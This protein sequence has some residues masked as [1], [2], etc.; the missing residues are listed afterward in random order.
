MLPAEVRHRDIHMRTTLKMLRRLLDR[1]FFFLSV[2]ALAAGLTVPHR[3]RAQ[4]RIFVGYD[5]YAGFQGP[6]WAAK[7]LGLFDKYGLNAALVLIPGS[8]RAMAALLSD[9]TQFAQG[10]ASAPVPVRMRGGDVVMVAAALNKFAVSFVAQKEIQ[11][12][13]DLIGKKVGILNFGGSNDLAVTL[14]FRE[15]NIPRSAVTILATGGAAERLAALSAKVIDATVLA[16]PE[17]VAATRMGMSFLGSLSDLRAFFPNTVITVRRPF[18]DKNRDTVKRF[19]RA[20]SDAI[21]RFKTDKEKSMAVYAKRLKQ[22]DPKIIED[23]YQYYAPK[24]SYPPRIERTGLRNVLE[25][26]QRGSESRGEVN[27]EQFIDESVID[28]LGREGFYK[29]LR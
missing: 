18:L 9:S 24:F 22:Q 20:Y 11:K 29:Q 23:T 17:T 5:G 26:S 25:L 3:I 12:P 14:A 8:A 28:E 1:S 2:L 19:V 27:V 21:Y 10:S 16:P 7:D 13:A 15:W 4:E 6:I